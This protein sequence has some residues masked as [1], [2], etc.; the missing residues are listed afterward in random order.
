MRDNWA[1]LE[2]APDWMLYQEPGD[3]EAGY[4]YPCDVGRIDLLAKHRSK[5]SW[6]VIE[7][8][9]NQTGDQTVGQL[10][11]Y[12][13]WVEQHLAEEGDHVC[14]MIVCRQA[15][16]AIGYAVSALKNVELRLYE[17]SFRLTSCDRLESIKQ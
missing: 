12:M 3:E 7:L 10:L 14:G 6:L 9:R 15:D 4:E 8:K 13:G 17:V 2:L 5:P 1:Q 11:R 16:N